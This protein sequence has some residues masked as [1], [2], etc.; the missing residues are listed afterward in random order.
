MHEVEEKKPSH[1]IK[2]R[3]EAASYPGDGA[4][5]VHGGGDTKQIFSVDETAVCWK[6]MLSRT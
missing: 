2:V 5:I 3:G 6:E 1:N 4:Q